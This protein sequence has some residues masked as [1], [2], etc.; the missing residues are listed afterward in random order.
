M[1]MAKVRERP[2][3][4]PTDLPGPAVIILSGADPESRKR[5]RHEDDERG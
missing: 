2:E 1:S 5:P 3:I 4:D